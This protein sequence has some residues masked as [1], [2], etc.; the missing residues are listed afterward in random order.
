LF[1]QKFEQCSNLVREG[2]LEQAGQRRDEQRR[3]LVEAAERA[4]DAGGLTAVKAR[5]LAREIG[6]ALGAIYNLVTDMDELMLRVASRTLGRLD[7][8]LTEA[9]AA[10]PCRTRDEACARLIAL[11]LAYRRFASGNLNLWRA[12]FELR[13]ADDKPTPEWSRADQL[14]LFRFILEP[15]RALIPETAEE[16]RQYWAQSLFSAVHGVVAL[17]LERKFVAVPPERLDE[18]LE[19]F[20]R[21]ICAGIEAAALR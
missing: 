1:K 17:G 16:E 14:A 21:A 6:V 8:A 10:T 19:R 4:I 7:A 9:S 2:L 15:L 13:I 3:R 20:V 5:D 18:Q 12:L 11:A